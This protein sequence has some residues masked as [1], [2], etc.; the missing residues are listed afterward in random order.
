MPRII[1]WGTLWDPAVYLDD[2]TGQAVPA[3]R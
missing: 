3:A 2:I 1:T